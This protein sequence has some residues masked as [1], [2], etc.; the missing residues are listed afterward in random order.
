[1]FTPLREAATTRALPAD[2]SAASL[3]ELGLGFCAALSAHHDIEEAHVFPP[4]ATRMPEFRRPEGASGGAA[5]ELLAQHDI[6]HEGLGKLRAYLQ[7][8][9]G[10][11]ALDLGRLEG[12]LG[13]GDVLLRHL[14]EEVEALGAENMRRYWSLEE[15]KAMPKN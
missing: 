12:V 10:G 8:C 4:L 5:P 7:R 15:V 9:K 2:M 14:D 3:I 6:M 13:W 11:E 1:M